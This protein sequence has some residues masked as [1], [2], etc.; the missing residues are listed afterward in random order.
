M[1]GGL[2]SKCVLA[3]RCLSFQGLFLGGHDDS[4]GGEGNWWFLW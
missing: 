4:V 3:G 1:L 2:R